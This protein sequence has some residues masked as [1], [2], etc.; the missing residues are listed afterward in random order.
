MSFRKS[1]L[2][3]QKQV[4]TFHL[5]KPLKYILSLNAYATVLKVPYLFLLFAS[6][7]FLDNFDQALTT[8]ISST[9]FWSFYEEISLECAYYKLYPIATL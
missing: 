3:N 2:K 1:I 8:I 5:Y 7:H 4:C 9:I 6:K